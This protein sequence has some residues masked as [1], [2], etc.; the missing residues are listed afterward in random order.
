MANKTI[1]LSDEQEIKLQECMTLLKVKSAQGVF[2]LML[3]RLPKLMEE[4]DNLSKKLQDEI[5]NGERAKRI[6][7]NIHDSQKSLS[8]FVESL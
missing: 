4:R 5:Y 6:L 3:E 7:R 8:A 2:E 1:R